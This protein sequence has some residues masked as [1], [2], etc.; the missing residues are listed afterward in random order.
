M[1]D[2]FLGPEVTLV[3]EEGIQGISEIC[4]DYPKEKRI[5]GRGI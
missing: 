1:E 3:W 5:L 4:P 2:K